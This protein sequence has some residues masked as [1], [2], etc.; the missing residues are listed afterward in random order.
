MHL[1]AIAAIGA[2]TGFLG[3]LLGKGGSA[4]ATP[5][6]HALGVPAMLAVAS[7]LPGTIPS[8]L[9]AGRTYS[10]AGQVDRRVAAWVIGCGV[11]ATIGGGL[12]SQWIGGGPLVTATDVVLV[13]L[14][15][16]LSLRRRIGHG[17]TP[18]SPSLQRIVGIAVLV[19]LV[20]GL[21]ANSGGFLLAPLFVTALGLPIARALG[22]SLVV[23]AALAVPGT[24]VHAE[25]GH[26][27]WSLVLAL[28]VSSVPLSYLGARVALRTDPARLERGYG[29]VLVV[30]GLA[31]ALII[32]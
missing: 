10:R 6:L 8:T 20:A 5:L 26:V 18:R 17:A 12:A 25:L 11:P 9:I 7:P 27:D 2:A 23:A 14:G 16:R 21:L 32:H 15:A 31:L 13:V 24:I 1:L 22:T 29:A 30:L 4:M 19:G 3:G 28:T